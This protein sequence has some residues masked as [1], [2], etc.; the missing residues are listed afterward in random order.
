MAGTLKKASSKT[1]RGPEK[2]TTSSG[3][4]G[5]VPGAFRDWLNPGKRY[6]LPRKRLCL[7]QAVDTIRGSGGLPVLAHPLQYGCTGPEL[8]ALT[9]RVAAVGIAGIEIYY[10]GYGREQRWELFALARE[11]GLLVTGGSDFH[12]SNKPEI[13]LGELEVP[14]G[15]A[16]R[17]KEKLAEAAR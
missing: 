8:R 15:V 5:S 2:P 17:L 1:S 3:W 9:E 7:E 10:T 4:A 16:L 14:A 11:Y 13:R 12:G 6:Y